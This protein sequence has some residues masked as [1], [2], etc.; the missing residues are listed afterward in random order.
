MALKTIPLAELVE[1]FAIYPRHAVD[2]AHV[3]NLA[4]ALRAGATLPP[5]VAEKATGRI[6]DGM[7]TS[8][9]HRKVH[10]PEATLKVD[11]RAY[12]DE[13]ALVRDA[14]ARNSAHG[15][16]LDSQDQVRSALMLERLGTS[17]ADIAVTL[18]IT[19]SRVSEI[20]TRV[21]VVAG[22]KRPAKPSQWPNGETRELTED[23]YA[24]HRSASGLRHAQTMRQ[25]ARELD[26]GLVRERDQEPA[27]LLY[28]ALGRWLDGLEE[29]VA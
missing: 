14:V 25:L 26:A 7:H 6:V 11:L 28:D 1:D 9:A 3:A 12:A 23:Q 10:G 15:R 2:D 5:P 27:R 22:E 20:T 19:A 16:R 8:R 4:E 18:H 13:A 17:A 21:V 29:E 24:V